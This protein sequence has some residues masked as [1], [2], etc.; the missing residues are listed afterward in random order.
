MDHLML[1]KQG[2]RAPSSLFLLLLRLKYKRDHDE[3][4]YPK[5]PQLYH[6][7]LLDR[8]N[9]QN[10]LSLSEEPIGKVAGRHWLA[11]PLASQFLQLT[12]LDIEDYWRNKQQSD[13]CK[14]PSDGVPIG[15]CTLAGYLGGITVWNPWSNKSD[16]N[17]EDSACTVKVLLLFPIRNHP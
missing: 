12:Q 5:K 10:E 7:Y 11:K 16:A 1:L 9:C 17:L 8:Q 3:R 15:S 4:R 2:V 6:S 14:I 13:R